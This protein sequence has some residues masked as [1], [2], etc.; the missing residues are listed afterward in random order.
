M[1]WEKVCP[2]LNLTDENKTENLHKE[3]IFIKAYSIRH[4]FEEE[5]GS[6]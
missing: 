3:N 4:I 1:N 6:L 5:H 2:N